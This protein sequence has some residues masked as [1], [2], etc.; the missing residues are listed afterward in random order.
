[1]PTKKTETKAKAVRKPTTRRRTT[2]AAPTHDQIAER[3]YF[4]SLE[5][6]EDPLTNWLRA[7]R[8]LLAA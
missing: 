3:A 5:R 8:E 4:L 6:G 2:V 7:E 1:M